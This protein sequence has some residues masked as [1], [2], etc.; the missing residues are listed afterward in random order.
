M[1]VYKKKRNCQLDLM[2]LKIILQAQYQS[3]NFV[4]KKTGQISAG[5]YKESVSTVTKLL[6]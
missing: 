6:I 4:E 5:T 3:A 1:T 2:A